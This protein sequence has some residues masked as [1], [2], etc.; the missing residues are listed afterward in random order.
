M[1]RSI[2]SLIILLITTCCNYANKSFDFN[3]K[4]ALVTG[5]ARGNGY[6]IIS[7]LLQKGVRGVTMIDVNAQRGQQAAQEL[8][9]KYG[10]GKVIFIPVNISQATQ[11]EYAFRVSMWHWNGLDIVI[12]NAGVVGEDNWISMV[13]VNIVGT[14]QGTYL[15]MQYMSKSKRGKGGVIINISSSL[16][17]DPA[18][19]QPV[20][21]ASKSFILSLDRSISDELY[22]NYNGI[23]IITV[24]PGAT[25]TQMFH[26]FGLSASNALN[27]YL[28]EKA[29]EVANYRSPQSTFSVAK[30]VT[31]VIEEGDN[32]GVWIIEDGEQ[33][34]EICFFHRK[35]LQKTL[36]VLT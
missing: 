3:G 14:V 13:N 19:H 33:P 6:A 12:N 25:D 24:S 10:Y 4:I 30:G 31:T 29:I 20:Y 2:L 8:N 16:G 9:K 23:R 36:T 17:M 11:F 1:N 18:H 28:K 34:Y 5:G 27:P 21:G 35:H 32:G 26:N 22:F 7:E 15:G